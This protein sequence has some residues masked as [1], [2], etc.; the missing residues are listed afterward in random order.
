MSNLNNL[1]TG[2]IVAHEIKVENKTGYTI[3]QPSLLS[4]NQKKKGANFQ[5]GEKRS[6]YLPASDSDSCEL[7]FLV[8]NQ[9]YRFVLNEKI[10]IH[11][12]VPIKV[13]IIGDS[14][15]NLKIET[16]REKQEIPEGKV[17]WKDAK[18]IWGTVI[19]FAIVI[20]IWLMNVL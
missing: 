14:P 11:N 8:D 15:S 17:V 4:G 6:L 5:A 2:P 1:F 3:S 7:E 9:P 20:V 19:V 13:Q 10:D 18:V 12:L 16:H